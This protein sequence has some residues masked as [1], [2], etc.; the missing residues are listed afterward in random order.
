MS[1]TINHV[2]KK[3]LCCQKNKLFKNDKVEIGKKQEIQ[4]EKFK[5]RKL[6]KNNDVTFHLKIY[7]SIN[8]VEA[9]IR[10]KKSRLSCRE[11]PRSCAACKSQREP[12]MSGVILGVIS[13]ECFIENKYVIKTLE[14]VNPKKKEHWA[15]SRFYWFFQKKY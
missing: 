8:L 9:I 5:H 7:Y 12:L 1:I 14:T 3:L 10:Q 4:A 6:K 11:S 2:R 15:S 13:Y